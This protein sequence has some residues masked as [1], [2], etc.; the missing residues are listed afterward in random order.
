MEAALKLD[1]AVG[2]LVK[3]LS[4][5]RVAAERSIAMVG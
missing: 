4:S 5:D 1:L 2:A 3:L